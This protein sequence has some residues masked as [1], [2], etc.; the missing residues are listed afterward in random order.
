VPAATIRFEGGFFAQA[1][2][3]HRRCRS[4]QTATAR[5]NLEAK[6]FDAAVESPGLFD[7]RT[8]PE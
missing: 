6:L 1:I 2:R 3:A 4:T 8:R 7:M 5:R